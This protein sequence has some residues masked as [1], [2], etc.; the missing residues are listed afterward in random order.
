[1]KEW[2]AGERYGGRGRGEGGNRST[3]WGGL[4]PRR[5]Q[6]FR[7]AMRKSAK[8]AKPLWP[9]LL[10]GLVCTLLSVFLGQQPPRIIQYTIDK[11]I[12]A[13]HYNL[14]LR[15]ILLYIGVVVASQVVSAIGGYW[16]NVAGQRLLHTLRMALYDHFQLLSLSYYD[17]KRIGDLASRATGDVAQLEGMIVNTL[18][19]FVQ[20]VFGIAFALYYM[21]SYSWQLALL[22]LIPVPILGVSLFFFTRK[23]RVVYRSI[24]DSMGELSGKLMENLS[25][26][27]V[28]K[29]FNR[30]PQESDAVGGV[31]RHVFSENI[32]AQKMSRVFYPCTQTVSRM[33]TVIVLGVGAYLISRGQF[34]VGALAAFLMYVNNFYNPIGD[35]IRTFDSIQRALASGERIFEVLDS[36]PEVQDPAIPVRVEKLRGEVEFKNVCFRYATGE[37][38]LHNINVH[39]LPGQRVALVGHSGAGKSSFINLIPRFY[40]TTQGQVLVDGI[41]VR[42]MRQC[43]LRAH[44]ALVLQETFLF[45]GSVRDNLLFGRPGASDEEVVEAAKIAN[46]HEFIER[47]E[48]GYDTEIGERG[49]KLSGGQKQRLAIARAVLADPRILILDEATSSVDSESEILIHQALDRLMVGRTTFIIAHRLSTVRSADTILVLESGSIVEHGAHDELVDADGRYAHMYR[50]QYWLDEE[51]VPDDHMDGP[52]LPD[53]QSTN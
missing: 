15:V 51:S 24:R 11:V 47:L 26:M 29:A 31:S 52:A 21:Y 41:D 36:V 27:R 13:N 18:N 12:G 25:G 43:D 16:T 39:A 40:D 37:E 8:W 3:R 14:L 53:L 30:E 48:Q 28:I 34:T 4:G 6:D 50:Q 7:S 22:V 45:N 17:D 9:I 10:F 23:V 5:P 35:F 2:G 44:I 33:G 42:E 1:M 20:Q 38:V 46:A 19:S 32:R 49:V